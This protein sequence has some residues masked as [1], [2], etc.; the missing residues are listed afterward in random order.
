MRRG[1]IMASS[2]FALLVVSP[3]GFC[4]AEVA[5]N[6]LPEDMAG[7]VG[8][9]DGRDGECLRVNRFN[10]A[11]AIAVADVQDTV[12]PARWSRAESSVDVGFSF[13]GTQRFRVD[14]WPELKCV[15]VGGC[16]G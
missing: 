6:E 11:K 3:L 10:I 4:I 1:V 2:G 12:G 9:W 8:T 15:R 7:V 5:Q 14:A 13:M 16:G